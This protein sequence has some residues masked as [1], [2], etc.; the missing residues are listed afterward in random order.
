MTTALTP[1]VRHP[2]QALDGLNGA[3]ARLAQLNVDVRYTRDPC[4][5]ISRFNSGTGIL[6][7]RADTCFEDLVWALSQAWFHITIGPWA[8]TARKV[9]ALRIVPTQREP[10]PDAV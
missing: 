7:I 1:S 5:A 2:R 9:P 4:A 6:T 3:L 8:S 10:L